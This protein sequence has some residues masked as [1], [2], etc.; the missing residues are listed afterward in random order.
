MH[1]K[2]VSSVK[3]GEIWKHISNT[4]QTV[5]KDE[6]ILSVMFNIFGFHI[7]V[8]VDVLLLSHGFSFG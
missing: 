5:T 8:M 3:G 1:N 4:F 6:P 2:Q 7:Y